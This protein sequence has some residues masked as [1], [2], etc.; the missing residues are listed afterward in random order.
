MKADTGLLP[1]NDDVDS[2]KFSVWRRGSA[3]R[4]LIK[5]MMC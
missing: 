3:T 5:L 4:Y 1:R 2:N